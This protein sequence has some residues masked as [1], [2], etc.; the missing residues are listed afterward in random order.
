MEPSK[1]G[2]LG[3]KK[4]HLGVILFDNVDKAP[5]SIID[6][7]TQIIGFGYLVDGHGNTVDFANTLIIMTTNVGCD[8]LWPWNCKCADEVQKFPVKEGLFDDAWE[9][10]HNSCYLSLLREVRLRRLIYILWFMGCH[11][12]ITQLTFASSLLQTKN[13]FGPQFLEY[14][15]DVIGFRSLSS[16]QLKAVARLQL[17]DLA[18]YMTQKGL[19]IYSS[20]AALDIIVR[21]SAWPGDR[22]V[23]L[24]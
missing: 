5:V 6:L 16:Q 22:I 1:K 7:L 2:E 19:I 15:D 4:R 13:H 10:N 24:S 3:V 17:R 14:V 23:C 18:V 9:R 12:Y 21:R 20:E 11:Y 8:Q